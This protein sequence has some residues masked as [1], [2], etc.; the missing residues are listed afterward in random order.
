MQRLINDI[1]R[2]VDMILGNLNV[3]EAKPARDW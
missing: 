1:P 2:K 3:Y